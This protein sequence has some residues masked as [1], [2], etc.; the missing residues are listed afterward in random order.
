MRKATSG[1]KGISRID[2][3]RR[4]I[5]GWYV[6][7]SFDRKMQSKFVSDSTHGGKEKGLKAAIRYR[8]QIEKDLGKPRTDRVMVISTSRNKTGILGVQW[9]FKGKGPTRK[10]PKKG[11]VFEVTWSPQPNVLRKVS[12]P[13]RK[14]GEEEAFRFA[15]EYRQKREKQMFGKVIQTEIPLFAK[16]KAQLDKEISRILKLKFP[17]TAPRKSTPV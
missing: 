14:L 16:V 2:N 5:H 11:L 13:V 1:H 3:D 9:G 4:N 7:V 6:R 12:F 8:N 15:V 17:K 10:D